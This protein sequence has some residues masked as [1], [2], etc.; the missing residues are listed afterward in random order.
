MHGAEVD[1][2]DESVSQTIID[3]WFNEPYEPGEGVGG[4]VEG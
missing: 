3:N 2:D 4:G 1:E